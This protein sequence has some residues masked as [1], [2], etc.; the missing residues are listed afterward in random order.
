MIFN[1]Y[2]YYYKTGKEV[3]NPLRVFVTDKEFIKF[4]VR[5]IIGEKYNVPTIA[6]LR[7]PVEAANYYYPINCCIKPTHLSGEVIF[8]RGGE[9]IDFKKIHRWFFTSYYR[10]K[11]EANYKTLKPKAIIEP[12][13]FNNTNLNDYKFY[14]YRGEP[15]L[16]QVDMDRHIQHKMKFYDTYWQEMPFSIRHPKFEGIIPKPKNL[17]TMLEIARELSKYFEF[18][19]V[20]LYTN[21]IEILVGEL[22]NCPGN[23]SGVFIPYGSEDEASKII[24]G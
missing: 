15:K 8:R 1:D 11:R 7:S 5:A 17:D 14:C 24:F 6:V 23:I 16:I 22:T 2:L 4:Y 9:P 10:R 18:I 13:I 20:D 19:R 21:D 12:I 3:V